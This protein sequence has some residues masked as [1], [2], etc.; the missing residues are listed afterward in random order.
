M[1]KRQTQCSPFKN[2]T[3]WKQPVELLAIKADS[4][5]ERLQVNLDS[6]TASLAA[7]TGTIHLLP[8]S[9]G[10]AYGYFVLDSTESD[11]LMH[12]LSILPDDVA[13][14]SALITLNEN[15]QHGAIAPDRVLNACLLYTS[16]CV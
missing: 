7:P 6:T 12:H 5:F 16:R 15:L 14:L 13:R 4:T 11:Y 10:R 2:N 1:Y 9:D 8:N 3:L